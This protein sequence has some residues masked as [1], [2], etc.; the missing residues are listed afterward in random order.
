MVV[1][2]LSSRSFCLVLTGGIYV[3]VVGHHDE[4]IYIVSFSS[5]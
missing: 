3:S 5:S 4:G 1:T 2:G